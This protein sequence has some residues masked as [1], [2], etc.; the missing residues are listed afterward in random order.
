[1]L[2][3]CAQAG[4]R[5]AFDVLAAR[6]RALILAMTFLRT[7]SKDE[8]EDLTQEVFAKAWVNLPALKE[9]AAFVAWLRQIAA[10]ACRDWY[11]KAPWPESLSD[12]SESLSTN[13][14]GPDD[15]AVAHDHQFRLRRAL[16]TLPKKNQLA[17]LLF[18][19]GGYSY[20]RIAELLEIPLTTVEGR[21]YRARQQ[22]KHLI[23]TESEGLV[24]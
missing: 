4:D 22:P 11:R 15:L 1:M 6:Y 21:I 16:L 13:T 8:A 12:L 24:S 3:R 5:A 20:E 10:N 7:G 19:W 9:P 17:L 2:V 18:V 23:S 14:P